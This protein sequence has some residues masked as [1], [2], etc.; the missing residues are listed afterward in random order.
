[1]SV[2]RENDGFIL[3]SYFLWKYGKGN[4]NIIEQSRYNVLSLFAYSARHD[5]HWYHSKNWNGFCDEWSGNVGWFFV[6]FFILSFVELKVAGNVGRVNVFFV[7]G[8][9]FVKCWELL[10]FL[11]GHTMYESASKVSVEIAG[12]VDYVFFLRKG[13]MGGYVGWWN[14]CWMGVIRH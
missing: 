14:M 6:A 13:S 4:T 11:A 10:L 1:M 8:L 3:S 5:D 7:W 9:L 12:N 2:D